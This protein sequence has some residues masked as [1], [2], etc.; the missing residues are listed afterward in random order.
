MIV[1]LLEYLTTP[2]AS[3]IR[4]MGYLREAVGIR[5]RYNRHQTAW[6]QHL[7]ASRKL[8]LDAVDKSPGRGR[9]AIFGAGLVY[10]LPLEELSR[11]FD[12][13]DLVD[14]VH[15]GPAKR[16]A[17][18]SPNISLIER[19]VT[20]SLLEIFAGNAN[21]VKPSYPTDGVD[22]VISANIAS[23]LPIIPLQWLERRLALPESALEELGAQLVAD[24]FDMLSALECHVA[25]IFDVE[26]VIHDSFGGE[27][28][29]VSSIFDLNPPEPERQW[30]WEVSPLGEEVSGHSV[31]NIV[32]AY[33]DWK[34]H[35][36]VGSRG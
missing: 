12:Q 17:R 21:A 10:D 31:R 27:T 8:M 25:A 19:D 1:E 15:L 34:K 13:V 28:G 18:N 20:G 26:R 24:H 35:N 9:V 36:W 7:A 3:H 22:L 32:W 23:Q 14:I 5:S 29:R 30:D 6:A 4:K 11:A 16:A 2:C 33:T